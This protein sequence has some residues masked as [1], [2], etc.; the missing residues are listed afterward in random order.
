MKFKEL[1]ENVDKISKKI[2]DI[3][4]S[5]KDR[6]KEESFMLD[7]WIEALNDEYDGRSF[8]NVL[9]SNESAEWIQRWLSHRINTKGCID[10]NEN[11]EV[12]VRIN[13]KETYRIDK[14]EDMEKE[15]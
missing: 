4:E 12:C 1:K 6:K 9:D 13:V 11:E 5:I 14:I 10:Y 8:W 7:V 15:K 2:F 3:K